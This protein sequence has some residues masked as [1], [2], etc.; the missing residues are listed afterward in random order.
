[1][2]DQPAPSPLASLITEAKDGRLAVRMDPEGFAKLDRECTDFQETI[3]KIQQ[4][5]R[6]IGR[7]GTWGFGDH[8]G[9]TLTSAPTMA[10]RFRAKASDHPGGDDFKTVLE[11]HWRAVEDIRQ[12]HAAIRDRYIAQDT[13]FAARF[14]AEIARL[15]QLPDRNGQPGVTG[16]IPGDNK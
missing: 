2:A 11:E 16:P 4:S 3:R 15:D 9:S 13:E 10:N 1:M 5:M 7:I 12:L 14:K 6:D 8:P